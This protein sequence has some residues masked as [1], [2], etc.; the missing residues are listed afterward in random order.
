LFLLEPLFLLLQFPLL[1]VQELQ[2]RDS[3]SLFLQVQ[4]VL[5]QFFPFP[6]GGMI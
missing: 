2:G 1:L 4:A 5:L 3:L 6:N